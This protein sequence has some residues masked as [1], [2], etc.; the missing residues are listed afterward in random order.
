MTTTCR[1]DLTAPDEKLDEDGPFTLVCGPKAAE[2][3][4]ARLVEI[5]FDDVCLRFVDRHE[6]PS[7]RRKNFTMEDLELIRSLLPK[8]PHSMVEPI[9]PEAT[10]A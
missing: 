7:H 4:L 3:R 8:D 6:S 9:A 5:G 1:V 10:A 2:E